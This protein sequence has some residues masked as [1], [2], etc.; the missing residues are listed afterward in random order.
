MK[1]FA[2]PEAIVLL[3]LESSEHPVLLRRRNLRE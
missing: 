2:P 3:M 1:R